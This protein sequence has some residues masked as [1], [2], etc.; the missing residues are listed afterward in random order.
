M[1][2]ALTGGTGFIGKW[3]LDLYNEKHE[4]VLIG[5]DKNIKEYEYNGV[6]YKYF[7]TDYSQESL[8]KILKEGFDAVIHLAAQ[9]P[10]INYNSEGFDISIKNINIS[11]NILEACKENNLS[12]IVFASSISNY[13]IYNELPW[14]EDMQTQPI[15]YYGIGKVTVENLCNYYNEK[16]GMKIKNLRIARVVGVGEREGFMLMNFINKAYRKETLKLYGEGIGRR[17]YIYVKDVA[18]AFVNSV[19]CKDKKGIFNIGT[20]ENLSHRELAELIN[21]VFD[22]EGNLE[23]ILDKEEDKTIFLMDSNKAKEELGWK[24]KWSLESALLD[25]KEIMDV[26]KNG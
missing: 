15:G 12:N 4:F 18:S 2:I 20:N 16:Y 22:N 23:L 25:M 6:R 26:Q 5:R 17:E 7:N 11:I 9:R 24:H 8:S 19:E 21:K 1:K 10:G 3:I 13:S 14:K